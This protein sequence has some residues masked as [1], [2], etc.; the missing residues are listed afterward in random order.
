MSTPNIDDEMRYH[1]VRLIEAN[2][3]IS[4]RELAAEL[5]VSVGKTNYCLKALMSV[6]WVKAGNFVRSSNKAKY[7]YVLTP[8]GMQEKV[9]ITARFLNQ[10]QMQYELLKTEIKR[11]KQE[12]AQQSGD[13][14]SGLSREN[15]NKYD[16]G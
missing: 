1:L 5:G 8:K 14:L 4:Q 15:D 16:A 10:K 9:R 6:G 11:L 13:A 12:L 2:P 7:A 3:H